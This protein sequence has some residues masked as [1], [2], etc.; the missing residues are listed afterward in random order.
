[1]STVKREIKGFSLYMFD[2]CPYCD[3]VLE[4]ME[5]LEISFEL[6]DTD[7]NTAFRDELVAATGKTMVPCL[8]MDE[9]GQSKWMH[10]SEDIIEFLQNRFGN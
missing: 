1:M 2:G 10:E 9:D 5:E 6:R 7:A 8:R 3:F 4:T